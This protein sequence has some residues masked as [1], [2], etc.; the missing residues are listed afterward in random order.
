ML[1]E[2]RR[3]KTK[4]YR[5]GR[6][7]CGQ[8]IRCYRVGNKGRTIVVQASTHAREYITSLLAIKMIELASCIE[9]NNTYLFVPLANPDG[10][11]IAMEGCDWL[12]T[13]LKHLHNTFDS[14]FWLY[15]ANARGVDINVNF[16]ASWGQGKY[17]RLCPHTHGYIG[18]YPHSELESKALSMLLQDSNLSMAVSLHSKGEV[19]YYGYAMNKCI[20]RKY[21]RMIAPLFVDNCYRLMKTKDSCGGY[22]DYCINNKVCAFTV[23]V[24]ADSCSHPLPLTSLPKIVEDN[25]MML[26]RIDKLTEKEWKKIENF[27]I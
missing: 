16:D 9:L 17:N 25:M 27:W 4:S 22:S 5:L 26:L 3:L 7:L 10:V 8:E 14:R 21:K 18:E 23:E 19:V 13:E 6:S 2:L 20:A 1:Q 24:G 12:G 11:R 15:K